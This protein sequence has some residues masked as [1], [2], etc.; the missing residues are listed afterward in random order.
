MVHSVPSTQPRHVPFPQ[1]GAAGSVHA[2][3]LVQ[4][5]SRSVMSGG[6]GRVMSMSLGE[7]HTL[8]KQTVSAGQSAVVSQ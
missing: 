3:E 7:P 4:K 1:T 5:P 6:S 2:A 8:L